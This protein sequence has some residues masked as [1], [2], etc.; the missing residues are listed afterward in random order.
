MLTAAVRD[1]HRTYPGQF[2]TDVRTSCPELWEHNPY[3]TPLQEGRRS[4]R[5]LQCHYPLIKRSNDLPYHCLHGFIDFLN[6]DLGLQIRPTA[7][8]GDLHL[9]QAEKRRCPEIQKRTRKEIPFWII[10]AGGKHDVTIKWWDIARYQEVVDHFRGKIQ[11]V[12]VGGFRDYHPPLNGV[13]DLRGQTDLRQLV[14]LVYHAQGV[15]CPVTCLMHLA[16]A[17]ETKPGRPVH[18]PCVVVAG[19]REPVHW[20]AYPHHQF[21]HTIGALPCCASGGCWKS[22]TQPLGDGDKRDRPGRLCSNLVG[23]LPRCMDM[24]TAAEVIRRIESY[25]QG[26]VCRY[27]EERERTAARRAVWRSPTHWPS[28][29]PVNK[30]NARIL[31]DKAL[32][33][34]PPYPGGFDGRGIVLCGGGVQYYTNAW[35]AIKTLRRLGCRLPIELWHLGPEEMDAT[36]AGLVRPMGVRTRDALDVRGHVWKRSWPA[37]AL[38]PFAMLHSRFRE[39]LLL[40]ADNVPVADPAYL[41]SAPAYVREGAVFWPDRGRWGP[42]QPIW[43][44]CGIPY[45]DEPEVESG[46]LIVDKKR[47]WR[48]LH[49]AMWMNECSRF[50]YEHVYGD[51]DTFRLAFRKARLGWAMPRRGLRLL[52]GTFCQHDFQGR[53]IFQHRSRAKWTLLGDNL[54][55]KGFRFE[56]ECLRDLEQLRRLWNGRMR[57]SRRPPS[58]ASGVGS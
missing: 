53:R 4:V 10:V 45:R 52:E 36:M 17:V 5:T 11:F 57:P 31:M 3:L 56:Q 35:V 19:G 49:L 47:C 54:T 39:V 14:R 51:K 38:K 34:T 21:I 18:R 32:A 48:G 2:L 15:L 58:R 44:I 30:Y 27:L 40:D 8:H 9:S 43:Q 55:V 12:Q 37:W 29:G 50:F 25:F 20:E 16:A 41:F 6:H 23:E 24:I 33:S 22:R 26:G 28:R 46:Q 13:I 42:T 7:F 1:L